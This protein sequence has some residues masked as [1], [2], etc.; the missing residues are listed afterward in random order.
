[1]RLRVSNSPRKPLMI[2]D[3]ECDFCRLWIERWREITAS[4]IDYATYQ[5]S[6]GLFPEIPIDHFRR[7][8][9]L[10]EPDG[11]VFFAAEA[12]YRSLRHRSARKWLAWSY[13]HVPGFAALVSARAWPDLSHR[14]RVALGTSGWTYRQRRCVAG[15]SVPAGGSRTTWTR[16]LHSLADALLVYL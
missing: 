3:G 4:E 7:S 9:V 1:M 2:W 8:M 10:I 5:D 12:V 6:A 13:D 16:C 14:I 15:E 11:E